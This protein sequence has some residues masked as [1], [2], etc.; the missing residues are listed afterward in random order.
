MDAGLGQDLGNRTSGLTTAGGVATADLRGLGPNRTLVLVDGIRL[1]IGS[2]NT[3][4]TQPAPDLDQIPS[5]LLER[6]DVVT[7]GASATYGSDAIAGVINFIMKKNFEG[8][9]IDGQYGGNFHNNHND[10]VDPLLPA[11]GVTPDTGT[12]LDGQNR[13]LDIIFGKNFDDGKGNVTAYLGYY[14]TD[15]VTGAQ[16]DWDQCQ[17]DAV[18]DN[19]ATSPAEDAAAPRTPTTSVPRAFSTLRPACL[20]RSARARV[21]FIAWWATSSFSRAPI[22]SRTRRP[23]S[24]R[25]LTFI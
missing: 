21:R 14:N 18:A 25:S 3:F 23:R 11:F 5:F 8:L 6:V 20:T 9:Q 19:L 1:G 7:G 12:H 10:T 4:I 13:Q 2:P 17:L 24:T 15:P 22:L 16:R